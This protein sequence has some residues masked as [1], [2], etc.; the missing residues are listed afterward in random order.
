M[1]IGPVIWLCVNTGDVEDSVDE[2]PDLT[3]SAGQVEQLR[4]TPYNVATASA[5]VLV[6]S[7]RT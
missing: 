6:M 1:V 2:H 5:L 4:L 3:Q 7:T